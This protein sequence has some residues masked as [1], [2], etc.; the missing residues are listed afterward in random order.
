M[1]RLSILT[2]TFLPATGSSSNGVGKVWKSA[3]YEVISL[4]K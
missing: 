3:E 2:A 4:M 1:K